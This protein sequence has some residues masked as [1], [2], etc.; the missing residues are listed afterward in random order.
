MT[1]GGRDGFGI[2]QPLPMNA[3]QM[4]FK[5]RGANVDICPDPSALHSSFYTGKTHM[6]ENGKQFHSQ[7]NSLSLNFQPIRQGN[8]ALDLEQDIN[9]FGTWRK[10]NAEFER[11]L[12]RKEREAVMKIDK[13]KGDEIKFPSTIWRS[14]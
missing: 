9:R 1:Y 5:V 14:P 10:F 12:T 4:A 7:R 2:A 11:R 8:V 13:L 3:T 6:M